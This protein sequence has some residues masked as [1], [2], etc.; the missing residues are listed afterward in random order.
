MERKE[1]MKF[2]IENAQHLTEIDRQNLLRIMYRR[3][4]KIH[5]CADGCRIWLDILPLAELQGIRKYIQGVM[6]RDSYCFLTTP[7]D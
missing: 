3:K 5:E 7:S 2:I 6:E 4:V 1:C